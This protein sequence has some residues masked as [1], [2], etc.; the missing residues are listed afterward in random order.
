MLLHALHD[1]VGAAAVRTL[2]VSILDERDRG[3]RIALSVIFRTN[4]SFELG[5]GDS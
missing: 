1:G 2:V 5:H 4:G 3:V